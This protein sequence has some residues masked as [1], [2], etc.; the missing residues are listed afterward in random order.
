LLR[1]RLFMTNNGKQHGRIQKT[2]KTKKN[3]ERH[4]CKFLL[5]V[6]STL[7]S[8]FQILFGMSTMYLPSQC[9]TMAQTPPTTSFVFHWCSDSFPLLDSTLP[10]QW[11]VMCIELTGEC[12]SPAANA[13]ATLVWMLYMRDHKHQEF[14]NTTSSHLGLTSSQT[15]GMQGHRLQPGKTEC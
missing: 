12:M 7:V 13:T 8:T 9:Y 11:C 6:R 10:I 14:T 3:H 4:I 5:W 15:S 1:R 2:Q